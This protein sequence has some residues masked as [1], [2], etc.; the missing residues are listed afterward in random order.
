MVY[1]T[2]RCSNPN[3]SCTNVTIHKERSE[4]VEPAKKSVKIASNLSAST[5]ATVGCSRKKR[6]LTVLKKGKRRS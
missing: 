5:V 1:E 6:N 4:W 3:C 2:I